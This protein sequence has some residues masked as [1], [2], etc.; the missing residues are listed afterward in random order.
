MTTIIDS[1]WTTAKGRRV[2]TFAGLGN[3]EKMLADPIFLKAMVNSAVYAA[4]TI[5]ASILLALG[6]AL[7]VSR[8]FRGVG[9][10]R[11]AFFTPTVLPLIAVANIWLFFYAPGF[12]LIDQIRLFFGLP[13][14][15]YA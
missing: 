4:I 8:P 6:M 10:I 11:M 2:S 5:P 15:N 7:L 13:S 1:F 14:A 3:Y 12:G 9:L